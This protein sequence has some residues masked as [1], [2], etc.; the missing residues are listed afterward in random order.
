[1]RGF[2]Q[3]TLMP[4]SVGAVGALGIDMVLGF[5]PLPAMMKTGPM[6]TVIKIAGAA[7][8]GAV[9]ANFV[10][11]ETANQI[12]AGS[13]TVALYDLLKGYTLPMLPP[14]VQAS[15]VS[16][17]ENDVLM[18]EYPELGYEGAGYPAG[19]ADPMSAYVSSEDVE[20]GVGMYMR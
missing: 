6:K 12:A 9:A 11:R 10:K 17:G 5:L 16:M 13:I 7:A 1:M 4:S 15:I 14:A 2:M 20:E 18:E 3:N 19:E 8:I